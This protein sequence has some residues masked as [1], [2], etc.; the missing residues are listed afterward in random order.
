MFDEW[1]GLN[2][3]IQWSLRMRYVELINESFRDA[4]MKFIDQSG[5][6]AIVK[7]YLET[8]KS[9]S[10]KGIIG[11]QDKDIGTWIKAGWVE[12][13]TFIDSVKNKTSLRQQKHEIKKEVIKII[14]NEMMTVVIPLSEASSCYYGR[15]TKW[16][17]SATESDNAFYTY[18]LNNVT[19]I[20]VLIGNRK[21][22]VKVDMNDFSI[23]YI[24]ASDMTIYQEEF[25]SITGISERQ[26]NTWV[27]QYESVLD[28][29]RD[30]SISNIFIRIAQV[31]KDDITL[32]T[33][34]GRITF[35]T[36]PYVEPLLIALSEYFKIKPH[37]HEKHKGELN[38]AL[39]KVVDAM[40]AFTTDTDA[41]YVPT[42]SYG[43]G[44][45]LLGL[46]PPFKE[47]IQR[48]LTNHY[49]KLETMDI[50]DETYQRSIKLIHTLLSDL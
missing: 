37:T 45:D 25:E 2:I 12:F 8:F 10:R 7:N 23:T 24:N 41:L 50:D 46:Y 43:I 40:E 39:G 21:L 32:S 13:T 11:G 26:I 34:N 47:F 38:E 4:R 3:L 48:T 1:M 18:F 9:L 29:A 20:Y 17:S 36:I 15:Q 28:E 31:T 49:H 22:A 30:Q 14:D 33:T 35:F 19:L 5:D 6:E 42:M 27:R 44:E 16:C